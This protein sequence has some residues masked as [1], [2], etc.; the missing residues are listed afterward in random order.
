MLFSLK[1]ILFYVYFQYSKAHSKTTDL[2]V[3]M[4]VN[5]EHKE[6]G[7][8]ILKCLFST[9]ILCKPVKNLKETCSCIL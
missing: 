3:G 9:Y 2:L 5:D 4:L 8:A 1:C 7:M 6:W